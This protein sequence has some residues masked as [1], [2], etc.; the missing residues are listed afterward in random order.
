[1]KKIGLFVLMALS[2]FVLSA[3]GLAAGAQSQFVQLPDTLKVDITALVVV[4]VSWLFAR[5][6][7]LAPPLRF[8]NE[9][10]L[11]LAMAIASQLIGLVETAT[12]DAYGN[13]VILA[14]QLVLA[15]VSLFLVANQLKAKGY[16]ALQ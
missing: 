6:I 9:F 16:R 13:V 5:L 8:L 12:P 3:C 15:V 2:V 14:L 1:M 10:R 11:P 4:A 7:A